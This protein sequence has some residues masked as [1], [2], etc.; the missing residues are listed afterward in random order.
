MNSRK[1]MGLNRQIGLVIGLNG[2]GSMTTDIALGV[3]SVPKTMVGDTGLEPVLACKVSGLLF[4][5]VDQCSPLK[6]FISE[7]STRVNNC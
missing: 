2:C 5:R 4:P 7:L 6:V 1:N 3:F